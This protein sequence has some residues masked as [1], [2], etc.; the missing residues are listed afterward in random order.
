MGTKDVEE[1]IHRRFH[2][3]C[4]WVSGNCYYFA[5]ILKLRFPD[6]VIWYDVI[7]NHFFVNIDG[8]DYDWTGEITRKENGCYVEWDEMIYYDSCLFD[9]LVRD[10][11]I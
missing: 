10:C 7:Y 11:I 1:F 9:R 2:I 5:E 3:D 6:A 4:N 8:H